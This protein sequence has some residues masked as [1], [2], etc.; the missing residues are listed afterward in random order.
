MVRPLRV[1]GLG[2]LFVLVVAGSLV[3]GYVSALHAQE[4]MPSVFIPTVWQSGSGA[5]EAVATPTATPQTSTAECP[6]SNFIDVSTYQQTQNYPAPQLSVTCS[7][8]TVTVQSNGIPNFEFVRITPNDLQAQNYTWQ[9]PLNPQ[10]A[11]QPSDLP[12]LGPVGIA[13]NGLPIYGPN[14][15]QPT[16]GD[17]YLD[18]ILDYCNG[19]TAPR[20]VY[21]L[22][23]RPDC[24]FTDLEGNTSLVIGY[25]FD[26][27]PILAPYMCV[28]A[29]CTQVEEV[30]SSWQRTRN[31]AAA[32]DAH[33]YVAGSGDLDQCN[34]RVL[35]DGSYAYYAT[36]TFPY[37]LGCYRG[38]VNGNTAPAQPNATNTQNTADAASTAVRSAAGETV[39]NPLTVLNAPQGTLP[40]R[41]RPQQGN[42]MPNR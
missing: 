14:E 13:V 12:L 18:G 30:Q 20:G 39:Q 36:D 34:G 6:S 4:Q 9:I 29:A 42:P 33:E 24:L 37:F 41:Q 16:Y 19:H 10:L 17:P 26:G 21:H 28:D 7:G 1:I 40:P 8:N 3:A 38:T 11:A 22:H 31:V 23:A 27:Y 15:A 32:W 25:A 35:A 5:A 2:L